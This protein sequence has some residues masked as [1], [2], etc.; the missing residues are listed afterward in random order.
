MACRSEF[1]EHIH[2]N[3]NTIK[4]IVTS[5]G[6]MHAHYADLEGL[7]LGIDV[8]CKQHT[9]SSLKQV[10]N[11]V[12]EML[13]VEMAKYGD[14]AR[15]KED[16]KTVKTIGLY[17]IPEPKKFGAKL[18]I[19]DSELHLLLLGE[20]NPDMDRQNPDLKMIRKFNKYSSNIV[21]EING[22]D[23]S[24][25]K[26]EGD[27]MKYRADL[28][29]H[30]VDNVLPMLYRA[31]LEYIRNAKTKNAPMETAFPRVMCG[32]KQLTPL[33]SQRAFIVNAVKEIL[34]V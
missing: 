25:R 15:I 1:H 12:C 2:Q 10:H 5:A 3:L 14:P 13:A 7:H 33:Q 16:L 34:G 8:M 30:C 4:S 19:Y 20:V 32:K 22:F 31:H 6:N 17:R 27:M 11:E 9:A 26:F 28:H 18:Q 23:E 24:I 21:A 29:K